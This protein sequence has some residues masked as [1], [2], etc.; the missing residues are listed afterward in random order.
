M[1]G[2]QREARKW[3]AAGKTRRIIARSHNVNQATISRPTSVN[4]V[5]LAKPTTRRPP[6]RKQ[7]GLEPRYTARKY[8]PYALAIG[9]ATL[10]WNDL[11]EEL[12]MLFWTVSGGGFG[13]LPLGIWHSITNDGAKR[14]ILVAAAR[15]SL[16]QSVER[17]K[18]AFEEVEWI[19]HKVD[20][21]ARY[22]NTAI[23]AP[24]SSTPT[25]RD[26]F[27][28]AGFGTVSL[29]DWMAV[30]CWPNIAG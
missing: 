10:S 27:P 15:A 9:E 22:R 5:R 1:Q 30:T 19:V 4:A 13:K 2:S 12:G 18:K 23:H 11:H 6:T 26:V 16:N 17:E 21:L 29:R 14:N 25:T 3:F 24:L 7:L 8:R 28:Q 20:K